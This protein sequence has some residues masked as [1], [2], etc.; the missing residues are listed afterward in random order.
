ME[1]F[2]GKT[3]ERNVPLRIALFGEL[4]FEISDAQHEHVI[5]HFGPRRVDAADPRREQK[6]D[7]DPQPADTSRWRPSPSQ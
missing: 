7:D 3:R 1:H 6:D 5:V 2:F 4:G